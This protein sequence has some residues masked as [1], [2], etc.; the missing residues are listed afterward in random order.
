MNA[1]K[2]AEQVVNAAEGAGVLHPKITA[3]GLAA[4]AT[5]IQV[6]IEA[7][8][9]AAREEVMV[10]LYNQGMQRCGA[11]LACN[12]VVD[13]G[14]LWIHRDVSMVRNGKLYCDL[15]CYEVSTNG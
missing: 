6:A 13:G 2:R 11:G 7:A 3:K 1:R 10:E 12:T 14:G 8:Q 15:A 4:L 5:S 9:R